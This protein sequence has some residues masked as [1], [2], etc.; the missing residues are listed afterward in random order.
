MT[1][2]EYIPLHWF[3]YA[4]YFILTQTQHSMRTP[5]NRRGTRIQHVIR[6]NLRSFNLH[7]F[8]GFLTLIEF[9]ARKQILNM[10]KYTWECN[11]TDLSQE[12]I[13]VFI[14]SSFSF[15]SSNALLMLF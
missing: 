6:I 1:I 5:G 2:R 9:H 13:S 4:A 10:P 7:V 12:N 11:M 15:S 8:F 14:Y 3:G